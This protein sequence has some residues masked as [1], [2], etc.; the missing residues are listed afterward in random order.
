MVTDVAKVY[1][2]SFAYLTQEVN[3]MP[4]GMHRSRTLKRIFVKTPGNRVTTHYRE[5]KPSKPVCAVC[6]KVLAG[7]PNERPTDMQNIPKSQ[8][9]PERP[10][11]GVLCSAC[12]REKMKEKAKMFKGE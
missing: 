4:R 9:R 6:G 7:V 11:G 5:R 3:K 8:K 1:A 10:Y 12:M 2:V